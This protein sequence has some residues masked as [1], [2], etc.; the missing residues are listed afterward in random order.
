VFQ[1]I[2]NLTFPTSSDGAERSK[3]LFNASIHKVGSLSILNTELHLKTPFTL[4]VDRSSKIQNSSLMFDKLYSILFEILPKD[5]WTIGPN[6]Y[7]NTLSSILKYLLY[8][9]YAM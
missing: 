3:R 7:G 6:V 8:F 2:H 4:V 9:Y 1:N 5:Y